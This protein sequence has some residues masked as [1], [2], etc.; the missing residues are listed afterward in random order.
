MA[1][2]TVPKKAYVRTKTRV[3][4]PPEKIMIK[5]DVHER[6]TISNEDMIQIDDNEEE[7]ERNMDGSLMRTRRSIRTLHGPLGP[8]QLSPLSVTYAANYKEKENKEWVKPL[9]SSIVYS[10]PVS[11]TSLANFIM[12]L[13]KNNNNLNL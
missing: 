6:Q 11:H 5:R 12:Q 2:R 13:L 7:N 3:K 9:F 1:D 8:N 4:P 10:L